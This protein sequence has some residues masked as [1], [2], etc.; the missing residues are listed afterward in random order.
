MNSKARQKRRAVLMKSVE[1]EKGGFGKPLYPNNRLRV[2]PV[3]DLWL[4][5]TNVK[6]K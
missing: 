2:H 1:K 3:L 6:G 4:F 5:S